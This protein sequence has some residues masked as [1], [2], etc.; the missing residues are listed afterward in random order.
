MIP[1]TEI[2]ENRIIFNH[3]KTPLLIRSFLV[4]ILVICTLVPIAVLIFVLTLGDGPHIG[5]AV[6]FLIFWGSG[7]I[8]LRTILWN[9]HGK[10]IIDLANDKIK[11]LADYKYFKDAR[12]EIETDGLEV[13]IIY[14]DTMNNYIGR[15]LLKNNN[16]EIETVLQSN[17]NELELIKEKI[18]TR[19]NI[20]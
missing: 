7:F 14:E 10:E 19:Y 18:K 4:L 12:Q 8:M 16:T 9:N 5:I 13:E 6:S 20:K 2:L 17:L 3:K 11:Y 1:N 15:L